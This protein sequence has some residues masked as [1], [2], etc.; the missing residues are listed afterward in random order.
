[1]SIRKDEGLIG[2]E[3]I[4]QA[5]LALQNEPTQEQLAHTLTVL[6]RRMRAGGQLVI[7]V[8]PNIAS[9]QM[10]PKTLQTSDGK[11]WWYAFTGFEEETKGAEQIQSTFL[12][13]MDKLLCTVLAVPD[14]NGLILNP[15]NRTIQLDKALIKIVLGTL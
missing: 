13:D 8:E 10:M 6:R 14:I 15:W 11:H 12:A 2:N 7:A 9:S 1:M 4:E 3:V 5:I